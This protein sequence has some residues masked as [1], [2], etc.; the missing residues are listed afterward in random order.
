ME[1]GQVAALPHDKLRR[2]PAELLRACVALA[3]ERGLTAF[4]L[5]LQEGLVEN[6][7]WLLERGCAPEAPELNPLAALAGLPASLRQPAHAAEQL[8]RELAA[9]GVPLDGRAGGDW[10]LHRALAA[11]PEDGAMLRLC[12]A[13]S[14]PEA[15]NAPN[16]RGERPLHIA[17]YQSSAAAVAALRAAGADLAARNRAG[18][19]AAQ[20]AEA[21]RAPAHVLEALR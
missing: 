1:V 2:L 20:L 7:M 21:L 18:Q 10:P 3:D 9:R 6:A 14:P 4:H 19:T 5:A 15:A 16:S 11:A 8:F 12:L 17:V 13:L